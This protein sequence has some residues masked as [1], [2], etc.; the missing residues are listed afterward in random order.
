MGNCCTSETETAGVV[1]CDPVTQTVARVE[2]PPR[3]PRVVRLQRQRV[4]AHWNTV[5]VYWENP[6]A[7]A[8]NDNNNNNNNDRIYGIYPDRRNRAGKRHVQRVVFRDYHHR[9]ADRERY[10][11]F[12]PIPN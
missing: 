5:E 9:R 1:I 7:A 6:Q 12:G 11:Y 3:D 2:I 8:A 10:L 4:P